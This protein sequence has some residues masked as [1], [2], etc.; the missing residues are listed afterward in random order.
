MSFF[1]GVKASADTDESIPGGKKRL[2]L[3][4]KTSNYTFQFTIGDNEF[5]ERVRRQAGG[6]IVPREFDDFV[7]VDDQ[8]RQ[9]PQDL[10]RFL[11]KFLQLAAHYFQLLKRPINPKKAVLVD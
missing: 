6:K 2:R 3:D 10:Q 11:G 4:A 5:L 8:S 7:P 9:L 1:S